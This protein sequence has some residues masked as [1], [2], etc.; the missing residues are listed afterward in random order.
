MKGV[1]EDAV[2]N[3]MYVDDFFLVG[4]RSEKIEENSLHV[5]L[6]M[7]DL[8]KAK[9]LF[10]IEIRRQLNGYVFLVQERYARDVIF[11]FN[12]E[13]CKSV[14]TPP[15]LGC[16]LDSSQQPVT[17]TDKSGMVDIPYGSAIG[18]LMYLASCT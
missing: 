11:R 17:N 13:V 3:A 2:D 12:M 16:Q 15:E 4:Q 7:K 14:S 6:K 10:G 9:F 8:G 18:S 1:G 5:K